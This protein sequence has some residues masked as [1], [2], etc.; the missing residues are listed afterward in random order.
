[1]ENF[2]VEMASIDTPLGTMIAAATER[3]V[4]MLEYADSKHLEPELKQL[5][6]AFGVQPAAGDNPHLD[7]L[8]RQLEEYF[9]GTRR[10]F[11]VPLD[12]VGTPFQKKV[13]EALRTIPYGIT[14][15]YGEQAARIGRPRSVRAVANANGR[16]KISILLPCHRVIGSDGTLTGYGGGIER[17][18]KLLELERRVAALD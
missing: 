10:D 1:M 18:R 2:I 9:A 15:T 14:V 12:T 17:K 5:S 4:C 11:D 13:W 7:A 16:N 3:G 8:K 6:A